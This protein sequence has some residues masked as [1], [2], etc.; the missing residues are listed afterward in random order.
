MAFPSASYDFMLTIV[1][2][3]KNLT[4]TVKFSYL[5][6]YDPHLGVV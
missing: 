4:K 1:H 5:S 3:K 2:G 6:R